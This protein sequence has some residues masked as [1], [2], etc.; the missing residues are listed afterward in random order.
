M[1][2]KEGEASQS[3]YFHFF[4]TTW[5]EQLILVHNENPFETSILTAF[6]YSHQKKKIFFPFSFKFLL[7]MENLHANGFRGGDKKKNLP[8]LC[9]SVAA[10]AF[11]LFFFAAY[12]Q[13]EKENSKRSN[14]LFTLATVFIP[15]LNWHRHTNPSTQ[16]K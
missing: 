4:A 16:C 10:V 6:S 13:S 9:L 11:S 3:K 7:L 5:I 14:G 2:E 12:H 8:N 15:K 1:N